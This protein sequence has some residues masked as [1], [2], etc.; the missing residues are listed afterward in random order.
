MA[1]NNPN[2]KEPIRVLCVFSSLD[3]G[4][5]ESMCMNLYRNIDR[6]KVQFDFV[7]HSSKKGSFE[8]EIISLGGKIFEAPRYSAKTHFQYTRW[9][10]NHLKN[11]SEHKIIHGHFFSISPIYFSVAHKFGCKTVA[12]SHCAQPNRNGLYRKLKMH[13]VMQTEKHSDYCFACNEESGKWLFP[14]KQFTVI[15]NAI[16]TELYSYNPS[17]RKEVKSE[18]NLGDDITV[19]TVGSMQSV[20]NPFGIIAIMKEICAKSPNAKLLWVGEGELHTKIEESI[21]E[22]NLQDNIILTGIRSDV[23]RLMQGMD[24]FILPS[25]SEGLPVVSIEAQAS[26]LPCFF[27]DRVSEDTNILGDCRYLPL[28]NPKLWAE[29]ILNLEYERKD[30]H[31]EVANAGYDVKKTAL[32]LQNF[33]L[34]LIS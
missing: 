14:H 3:R 27:S 34:D 9:W 31:K 24:V 2:D 17:L 19:G 20:K 22:N 6:S 15:N 21:K 30:T 25:F 13:I 23:N 32:Y 7:K 1:E 29:Q 8:D 4:G 12:H 33:Y 16:D 5:A 10:K 28:D 18:F 26:A 11:H